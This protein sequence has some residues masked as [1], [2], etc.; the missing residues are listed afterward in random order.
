MSRPGTI[1]VNVHIPKETAT[2]LDGHSGVTP[3]GII[4]VTP[5][6]PLTQVLVRY[7]KYKYINCYNADHFKDMFIECLII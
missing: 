7:Q 4:G 5:E 2:R 1:T 3:V 6:Q